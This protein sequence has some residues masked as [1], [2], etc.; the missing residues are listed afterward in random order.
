MLPGKVLGRRYELRAGWH[1][2]QRCILWSRA[3]PLALR[4]RLPMWS[5]YQS[6]RRLS[7]HEDVLVGCGLPVRLSALQ[8]IW[9]GTV[10]VLC[11][12]VDGFDGD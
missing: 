3:E 11:L 8:P 4:T 6:E 9:L 12:T 5:A 1:W 7:L 2:Y 10:R